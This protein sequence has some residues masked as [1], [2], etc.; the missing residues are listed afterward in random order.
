MALHRERAVDGPSVAGELPLRVNGFLREHDAQL[1]GRSVLAMCSGGVDS[2]VLVDVLARMPHGARPQQLAVLFLDHGLRY[3]GTDMR[4]AHAVAEL[5][6]LGSFV[7]RADRKWRGNLQ[8]QARRWRYEIA[9]QVATGHGFDV[10]ATGHTA[11][12][13]MET[14]LIGLVSASGERA[15][16]GIPLRRA[17][18]ADGVAADETVEI[19]RPLLCAGREEITAHARAAGL[20][21]AED[22]TN[23]DTSY[24]RNLIRHRVVPE[25]LR[26]FPGAARNVE[27]SRRQIDDS[28]QAR[29][30]IEAA[31]LS[32]WT[33]EAGRLRVSRLRAL[34][35][36]A[37][38]QLIARWLRDAGLGRSLSSAVV[39]QCDHVVS[40]LSGGAVDVRGGRVL[41][42]DDLLSLDARGKE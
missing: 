28:L 4:A 15:L 8:E 40:T 23:R 24:R 2:V 25:L 18:D 36:V 6:G 26:A 35:Q 7:E 38:R 12:D 21:W 27:R 34:P 13:Q 17:A 5:H 10:I 32:E 14:V 20:E 39:A 16:T 41:L 11:S 42:R 33:D 9:Q 37:R 1:T 22:P 31:L 29:E 19:V 30:P 3:A